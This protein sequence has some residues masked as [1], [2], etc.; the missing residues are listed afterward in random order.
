ML[1]KELQDIL[2]VMVDLSKLD[3]KASQID[4]ITSKLKE[5]EKVKERTGTDDLRYIG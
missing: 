3:E 1:L 4:K 2:G 5:L